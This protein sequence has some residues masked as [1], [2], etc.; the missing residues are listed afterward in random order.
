[1]RGFIFAKF[2]KIVLV[3]TY[4]LKVTFRTFVPMRMCI[5]SPDEF[6]MRSLYKSFRKSFQNPSLWTFPLS[7]LNYFRCPY[8]IFVSLIKHDRQTLL[9]I[10]SSSPCCVSIMWPN[11]RNGLCFHRKLSGYVAKWPSHFIIYCQVFCRVLTN[12]NLKCDYLKN[13]F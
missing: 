5:T 12:C 11:R 13:K 8:S 9:L 7:L 1:M 2:A 3:K 4:P 6:F 10:E